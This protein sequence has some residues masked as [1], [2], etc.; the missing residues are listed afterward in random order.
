MR[1]PAGSGAAPPIIKNVLYACAGS[2]AGSGAGAASAFDSGSLNGVMRPLSSKL[3]VDSGGVLP[4]ST[5]TSPTWSPPNAVCIS[6]WARPATRRRVA[7]SSRA[8]TAFIVASS[9][10]ALATRLATSARRAATSA[11]LHSSSPTESGTLRVRAG[12]RADLLR[13]MGA[14]VLAARSAARAQASGSNS[15]RVLGRGSFFRGVPLFKNECFAPR[16][17][18]PPLPRSPA[19]RFFPHGARS[20]LRGLRLRLRL[21]RGV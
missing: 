8:V 21:R 17:L 14:D 10:A 12:A 20:Y 7:A 19:P 16:P 5:C 3:G 9:A 11:A 1:V 6:T 4:Q 2:G 18:T 15:V 13:F